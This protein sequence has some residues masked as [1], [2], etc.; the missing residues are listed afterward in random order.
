MPILVEVVKTSEDEDGLV[1]ER[2][3]V[4]VAVCEVRIDEEVTD[5]VWV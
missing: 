3:R 2:E 5:C 1:E 4:G